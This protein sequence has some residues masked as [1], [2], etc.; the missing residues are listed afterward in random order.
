MGRKCLDAK[1]STPPPNRHMPAQLWTPPHRPEPFPGSGPPQAYPCERSVFL[2]GT[3]QDGEEV[4]WREIAITAL[5]PSASHIFDPRR[6]D[7]DDSWVT[8]KDNPQFFEQVTGELDHLDEASRVLMNFAP[9]SPSPLP[10]L[11]LGYLAA[12]AP[13]KLLVC[14]PESF[15]KKGNVGIL[16]ERQ[17]IIC[18]DSLDELLAAGLKRLA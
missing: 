9:A 12:K 13:Q 18:V 14:C 8:K 7:W 17:G 4:N 3:V 15:W 10:L 1:C 2:A 6:A 5:A 11:E 16:R